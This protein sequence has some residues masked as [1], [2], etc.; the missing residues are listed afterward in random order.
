[1]NRSA[2]LLASPPS[3]PVVGSRLVSVRSRLVLA[4]LLLA[5]LSCSAS[6][7]GT[8]DV[9]RIAC[10][11]DGSTIV[12]APRVLVQADGV[13]F[14]VVNELNKRVGVIL[15]NTAIG[16]RVGL[17]VGSTVRTDVAPQD[18]QI[19]C[20]VPPSRDEPRTT[21]SLEII[22]PTGMYV[23]TEVECP[24]GV[25]SGR[26]IA[27]F[28]AA[29]VD[30]GPPSLQEARTLI[31]GLQADDLLAYTGYRDARNQDVAVI[32]EG[33]VIATFGFVRFGDSEGWVEASSSSCADSGLSASQ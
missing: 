26:S 19:G 11:P 16:F 14:E 4:S 23:S 10:A 17:S 18:V 25:G 28:A 15:E 22:D 7:V 3:W 32:R 27:D 5:A 30:S 29:P 1:M 31:A 21:A 20:L 8:P 6:R 24:R 2:L 13:H 33:Q 12:D 9:A